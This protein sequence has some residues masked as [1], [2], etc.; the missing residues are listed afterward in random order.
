[1]IAD[2]ELAAIF[3]N[4]EIKTREEEFSIII[5]DERLVKLLKSHVLAVS[6]EDTKSY[7]LNELTSIHRKL[8]LRRIEQL[9]SEIGGYLK[10]EILLEI[11]HLGETE[12]LEEFKR[13]APSSLD[14]YLLERIKK[15]S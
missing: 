4:S 12:N 6:W 3:V 7:N 1:M 9:R 5:R 8:E 15:R 14:D 13:I 11:E 10:K 2:S